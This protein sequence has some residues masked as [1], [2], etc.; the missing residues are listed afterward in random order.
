MH[1]GKRFMKQETMTFLDAEEIL[2]TLVVMDRQPKRNSRVNVR[3]TEVMGAVQSKVRSHYQSALVESVRSAGN[4]LDLG[5]TTFVLAPEFGFCTGVQRAIDIAYAARNVF[6]K[7]RIFLIGEIIHNPEVN[8]QLAA[9]GVNRLP[10]KAMSNE[11]DALCE[12]DVVIVPAFGVPVPFMEFLTEK[13]V[14]I[15]DTTCGDVM[16]VWRRVKEF[17]SRGITSIIHGKA[18]HE[19]TLA[20]AS[21]ALGEDGL[22]KYVIIFTEEDTRFLADYMLGH[23]Q[24]E[25]FLKRF[26]GAMSPG[27]DPDHDLVKVGLANQTTM[28]K[29]ETQSIQSMIREAIIKRDGNDDRYSVFD[30]ICGATQD[31]QNSL[32]SLL[33]EKPDIMFVV[34]GYNSSNTTHLVDIAR[35]VVPTFFIE[36][37]SCILSLE[38]VKCFDTKLQKIVTNSFPPVMQQLETPVKIGITAGAS[39]PGNLIEETIFRVGM[40]RGDSF[41]SIL[42]AAGIVPD[43]NQ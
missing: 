21:R 43:Q 19:E 4:R 16:K 17:A 40:L 35:E 26:A 28:L 13:G 27:F 29:S 1:T 38:S 12:D 5:H 15:V 37:A 31:R 24:R 39:C 9:M 6:P 3:R 36:G 14:S 32:F 33:K 30:T 34:G 41:D 7:E 2:W 8:R 25:E 10:W 18:S 23:G 22:G 42:L 20:T 11:Y